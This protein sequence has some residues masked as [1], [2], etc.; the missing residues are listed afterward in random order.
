MRPLFKN[1]RGLD[2]TQFCFLIVGQQEANPRGHKSHV[3]LLSRLS[4]DG[5]IGP[6]V[7]R[8]CYYISLFQVYIRI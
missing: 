5:Q 4:R 6:A 1:F 8:I 3:R 7:S 2:G